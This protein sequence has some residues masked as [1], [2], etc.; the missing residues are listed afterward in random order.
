M[1][2]WTEYCDSDRHP[3][4]RLQPASQSAH[5]CPA[6]E[7][8]PESRSSSCST[9][10]PRDTWPR[11]PRGREQLLPQA[12]SVQFSC[13][14]VSHSLRPHGL[15]HASSP[16]PSPSP[17]PYSKSCPSSWWCHPAILSSVIPFSSCLQSFPA[18]GSFPMSQLFASGGQG[19]TIAFSQHFHL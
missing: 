9:V 15:Q 11:T 12:W 18:S 19:T 6:R 5:P 10:S 8:P 2:K 17:R 4:K 13:S 7:S 1:R 3:R 14:I 16:C